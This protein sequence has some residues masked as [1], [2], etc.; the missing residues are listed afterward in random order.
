MGINITEIAQK[1]LD[2]NKN[3]ANVFRKMYDLFYNPKPLDVPFEYINENG[4]KI[5]TNIPNVANFRKKIWDDVGA[6]LGY[7]N[8]RSVVVNPD[9]GDDNN[10]GVNAP[11]KTIKKAIETT[12]V[13]GNVTITFTSDTTD[14]N[15][16]KQV[17]ITEEHYCSIV[18]KNVIFRLIPNTNLIFNS[19]IKNFNSKGYFSLI[20]SNVVFSGY[21]SNRS[22]TLKA[23]D[24]SVN[25]SYLGRW[26]LFECNNSFVGFNLYSYNK[27][28]FEDNS[29]SLVSITNRDY[30]GGFSILKLYS[31]ACIFDMSGD[32]H[33]YIVDL[34]SGTG[35]IAFAYYDMGIKD[36]NDNP[37]A[38]SDVISGIVKDSNGIPR[39]FISNAVI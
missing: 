1:V 23:K 31:T 14:D 22:I 12:P 7:F 9:S 6:A 26:S 13:G 24:S 18:G 16:I 10:D 33:S 28:I 11:F 8:G 37:V 2:N 25:W 39:N 17:N 29:P 32:S 38:L 3:A 34:Y 30:Y 21:G 36:T 35:T 4:N 5:T 20:N 27:I 15:G 19:R